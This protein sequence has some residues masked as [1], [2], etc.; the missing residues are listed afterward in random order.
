MN[1]SYKYKANKQHMP[2][3]GYEEDEETNK[4]ITSLCGLNLI[5]QG[6][7]RKEI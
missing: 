6:T 3:N 7:Q 1:R 5:K 4:M 2:K